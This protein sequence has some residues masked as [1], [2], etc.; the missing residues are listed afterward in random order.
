MG[1]ERR[2]ASQINLGSEQSFVNEPQNPSSS[3]KILLPLE[4]DF[5]KMSDPSVVIELPNTWRS[6]ERQTFI[7]N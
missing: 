3:S 4:P 6:N 1:S 5:S 7:T 2:L